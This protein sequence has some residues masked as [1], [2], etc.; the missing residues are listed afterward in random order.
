MLMRSTICTTTVIPGRNT[1]K[2]ELEH[3]GG[4]QGIFHDKFK[5]HAARRRKKKGVWSYSVLKNGAWHVARRGNAAAGN[6]ATTVV[7]R[8]VGQR[9]A[10]SR[11]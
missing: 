10:F 9:T 8:I 6:V 7:G 2:C 1:A 4:M 11:T 3:S 5:N